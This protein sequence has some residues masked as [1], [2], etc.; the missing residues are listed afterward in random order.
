MGIGT[1]YPLRGVSRAFLV[2]EANLF[3][4]L[5]IG[6]GLRG[7]GSLVRCGRGV[8]IATKIAGVTERTCGESG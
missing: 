7:S 8:A 2:G 1:W 4:S 3:S 5:R 6:L